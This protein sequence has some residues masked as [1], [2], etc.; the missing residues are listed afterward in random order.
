MIVYRPPMRLVACLL[1]ATPL[2]ARAQDGNARAALLAHTSSSARA[3][4]GFIQAELAKLP[5]GP[6]RT[7]ARQ[8]VDTPRP[9]FLDRLATREARDAVRRQ[10]VEAGLLDRGVTLEQLLAPL[11]EQGAP[12]PFLAAPGGATGGHHDYPGG[13]AEHTAFNLA[14]ALAL[15]QDYRARYGV[16][17]DHPTVVAAA[18][19]HDVFKAWVLQW[20]ADGTQLVQPAVA[21]TASHHPFVV[22]E[23]L[24]RKLPADFVVALASAHDPPQGASYD[25]LVGYLRAAALLAGVDA[26]AAGVLARDGESWKLARPPAIEA[27]LNHLS[28]HDYVVTDPAGGVVDGVLDRLL[29]AADPTLDDAAR[30]WERYRVEAA[31]PGMRLYALWRAGGDE[32]VRAALPKAK[33]APAR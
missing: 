32:A 27:G 19:L 28:D 16:D 22:A 8:L 1:L 9:T 6:V 12:Q 26:V 3:A 23:A 33:A 10:L 29:L 2:A 30:R 31:V 21:N 14:A 17:L 24:Y 5:Q 7:A 15:E 13:L 20:R 11:P 18:V 4:L 25:R